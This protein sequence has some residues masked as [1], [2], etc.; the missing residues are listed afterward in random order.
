M[1]L[2]RASLQT[3]GATL[4]LAVALACGGKKDSAA[5][6]QA[7]TT[8]NITGTVTYQRVPLH[9][10]AQGKP[11]G[12]VDASIPANLQ[13]LP[14]RGVIVRAYQQ[15]EQTQ[16]DGTKVYPWRLAQRALTNDTGK[17]SLLLAKDRNTMLEVI[18]SFNDF[19]N[20]DQGVDIIAEPGGMNSPTPVLDRKQYGLR[21]AA[22]GTAPA[23]TN[24]PSSILTADS[25]VDFSVGLNDA[26]W[27]VNPTVKYSTSETPFLDQAV[28]ETTLPGRTSGLGSGSRILGIGD[29]VAS[30]MINYGSV[31][32]GTT[33]DLH[34]WPGLSEAGGSYIEYDRSRFSQAYDSL[35]GKTH[36]FGTLR[37]G[38]TND[39]AWDEGIIFTLL[40]R[41]V[42]FS[43][44]GN[45]LIST[46]Q[47]PLLPIGQ[48]LVD[49]SPDMARM[50]GMAEAMAANLLKSPYLADTQG[51]ALANPLVDIRDIQG[52]SSTDLSAFSARGIRALTWALI[53]K[54]NGLS[55]TS[56]PADWTN[57]NPLAMTRFFHAS[58]IPGLHPEPL[59]IYNQLSR[60]KEAKGNVEPV[61]LVTVFTDEVLTPLVA[62][63]GLTW[64]RPTTGP[65]SLFA[66]EWGTDLNTAVTP[67][68]PLPFSMSKAVQINGLYP[69][70][71]SGE[72]HYAS[73]GVSV[74]KRYNISTTITP[75]LGSGAKLEL[76]IPTIIRTF[77]FSGSGGSTGAIILPMNG[78]APYLHP[79]R[80]RLISPSSLQPDVTVTLTFTP[81]P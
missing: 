63:F 67:L 51:V 33:L 45:R 79:V 73:F 14:A 44:N 74:D 41:G 43:D 50:E 59:N 77:E 9:K 78:T 39:D 13:T 68:A 47:S 49:L 24:I 56:L 30:F 46:P 48:P 55:P 70:V 4:L 29:S 27:V 28:L 75:S 66:D 53:L 62:P 69:N 8:A 10:D 34:Y 23:T 37:G 32:P 7:P 76:A 26:W 17:Y 15:F 11:D 19:N 36:Y 60:L 40:A 31:T 16:P 22:D 2:Y 80:M 64:P 21:K 35:N 61:D 20:R 18:S 3:L 52:L 65:E 12:L 6:V 25:V 5:P 58:A 81:A 42:I 57:I 38:A 54:A 72:I 1:P 71:S